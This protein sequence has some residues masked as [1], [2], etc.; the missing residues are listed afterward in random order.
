MRKNVIHLI[1]FNTLVTR[2][3]HSCGHY[4]AY[5]YGKLPSRLTTDDDAARTRI[6][7]V[8]IRLVVV[9]ESTQRAKGALSSVQVCRNGASKGPLL[10][11]DGFDD[12][13][14]GVG[15]EH[16]HRAIILKHCRL[17]SINLSTRAICSR[18]G[19]H[20][21]MLQLTAKQLEET[22]R[23][24]WKDSWNF[25]KYNGLFGPHRSVHTTEDCGNPHILN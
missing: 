13:L 10:G 5:L 20:Q 15:H 4:W 18:G 22:M 3:E 9:V 17:F 8:E 25:H 14:Y 2:I 23:S 12:T 1:A 11:R 6:V 7:V 21:H 24:E 16:R 19:A